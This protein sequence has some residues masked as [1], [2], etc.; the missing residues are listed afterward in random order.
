MG[1]YIRKINNK[2]NLENICRCV[3]RTPLTTISSELRTSDNDLSLWH[4][5]RIENLEDAAMSILLNGEKIKGKFY[6]LAIEDKNI[7]K[8]KLLIEQEPCPCALKNNRAVHFN[9]K[10]LQLKNVKILLKVY[11]RTYQ[12]LNSKGERTLL[13]KWK[14][15][16][17]D[18]IVEDYIIKDR[19]DFDLLNDGMKNFLTIFKNNHSILDK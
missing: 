3:T 18:K 19:I 8:S 15:S 2:T 7:E 6:F 13:L 11:R 14:P 17:T 10:H 16:E 9:L 5:E 1:Y 4:I 12:K